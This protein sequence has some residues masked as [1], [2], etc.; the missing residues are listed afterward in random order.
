VNL[1]LE[2]N[3]AEV[4][5]GCGAKDNSGTWL[6]FMCFN[7]GARNEITIQEQID[8]TLPAYTY[9]ANNADPV[10]GIHY[11]V[12]GE[13]D[14]W[15]S[16]F[17]WGRIADGHEIREKGSNGGAPP[18]SNT[19]IGQA[20]YD[21]TTPANSELITGSR[22][23]SGDT[24][25]PYLQVRKKLDGGS[26]NPKY[27]KFL[28]GNTN[29]NTGTPQTTA[30]VLWRSGRFVQNDPC[31]H[32]KADGTYQN[33]WHEGTDASTVGADGACDGNATGWRTPSQEEWGAI[34]KGGTISG[35]HSIATANTW[36]WV[37]GTSGPTDITANRGY[38]IKPNGDDGDPNDDNDPI[39]LFLPASGRRHNNN[40]LFYY[41]GA[42]GNYWSTSV[43]DTNVYSLYFDSSTVYPAYSNAH[44]SGFALRCIKN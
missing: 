38:T 21:D 10:S 44:A 3:I 17:Q 12:N 6:S 25:H 24:G 2:S 36:V 4:A 30:D 27:G 28:Y 31:A 14:L 39:T 33:F 19:L 20:T 18:Y 42:H 32:Y 43:T 11:Y 1:K 8:A 37:G 13:N 22:C 35:S 40:G 34:Y 9:N 23:Y 15:G 7:L 29:W 26:D 16:L 41:Q 5:V